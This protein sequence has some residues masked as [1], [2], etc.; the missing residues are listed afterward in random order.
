LD[1]DITSGG[2]EARLSA[3][4]GERKRGIQG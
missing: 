4:E 2:I 1:K 3:K